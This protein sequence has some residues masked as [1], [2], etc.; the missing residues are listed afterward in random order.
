MADIVPKEALAYLKNKKL[1]PAFSYKDVWREEHATAFTVAKAMQLDVLS[2]LHSAVVNAMEKG[3]SFE[4]FK[5][6]LKPVLQQKGWWGKK[7]M[8]DPLTGETV[9]AQLGSDRRLKTIYQVNMRSSYQKGQYE[10]TMQ[11]DLHPY[12]MYRIGPSVNHR[13][14]HVSWD[15]LILPKDD[16]WWDSHFPPNGWGCKC[17]TRAVTE[18][19]KKQYEEN[20][21]PT[22]PLLDGTGGGNIPAKTQAPPLKYKTYFNERKGTVE[23]VPE[24]VDPAFNWNQGKAGNKAALQKLGESKQNYEAAAAAKP[25]KEY[26]TKKKLEGDIAVIDAHIKSA[27]DQKTTADLEAKK[28]EYQQLLDK[29]SLAADKKKL[30]KEQ[31][32]LQKEFDSLNV[33]TYSGIWKDDITTADWSDKSASIQA[34][35]D[36]FQDKL[37]AGG[38]SDADKA[39]FEQ[40][41]KDI[42]EFAAEGKHY[43]EVRTE[44][45]KVQHSLTALKKNGIVESVL[46]DAFSQARKDAALWAK[47]PKESDDILRGVCG[48]VWQNATKAERQAAYDYTCGSGGFN[49]PLRGYDGSWGKFKGIGKVPLDNEGRAGAIEYL[50]NL[51]DKSKYDIDI[52]LQRGVESRRGAANFLQ[53]AEKDLQNLTQGQLEQKLLNKDI[54]DT[55][56][57]SC[58]SAKGQGFSGYIFNIYCPKGTKMIYAE[59]FSHYGKGAGLDWN[60]MAKQLDFGSEDETIIQRGTTF[61]VIK[62]EKK[63]GI[64]YF[65]LDVVSQITGG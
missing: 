16:P 28:A 5:K 47:S 52:W 50:A 39:K 22:A 20:G 42:D 3:Q 13:E 23:Q 26:L 4:S 35:K 38:L 45:K 49:R 10:R 12:L 63:D 37:N 62:V 48:K 7:E 65:D 56:F 15:G 55:A 21:I 33:K 44:L 40:F 24:G 2:D 36:Y 29:K 1:Q 18:V 43:H 58:G 41:L 27:S 54:I 31:A 17:Y 53:I 6:N 34:K 8:T 9:N 14:D 57:V 32:A 59:P 60:G 51:I 46:D 64:T 61:K 11:S 30:L 19:R 25:K